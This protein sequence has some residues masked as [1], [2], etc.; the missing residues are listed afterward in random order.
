MTIVFVTVI[1]NF[2]SIL[3]KLIKYEC[4]KN[5]LISLTIKLIASESLI[6]EMSLGKMIAKKKMGKIVLKV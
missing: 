4:Q 3:H 2:N 5:V 6:K 1:M